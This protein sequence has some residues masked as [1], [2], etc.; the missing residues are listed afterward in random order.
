MKSNYGQPGA[1]PAKYH[2]VILD[3]LKDLAA[4][5]APPIKSHSL[6]I[7]LSKTGQSPLLQRGSP[8]A[9]SYNFSKA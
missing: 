2:P 9:S 5:K 4:K 8:E 7:D 6:K 1:N 3:I